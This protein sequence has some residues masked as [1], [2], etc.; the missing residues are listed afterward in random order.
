[1]ESKKLSRSERF[2]MMDDMS[3]MSKKKLE[4]KAMARARMPEVSQQIDE[5]LSRV[6]ALKEKMK[7]EEDVTISED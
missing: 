3:L 4:I 5:T 2:K 1:M 6:A 7:G